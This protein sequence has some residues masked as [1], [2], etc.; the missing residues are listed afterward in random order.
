[1]FK[2]RPAVTERYHR[3]SLNV[4][5]PCSAVQDGAA[6]LPPSLDDRVELGRS[7]MMRTPALHRPT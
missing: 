6:G 5:A 2:L 7:T 3:I 1:M 4:G